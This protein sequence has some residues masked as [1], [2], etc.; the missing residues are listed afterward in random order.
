MLLE[1]FRMF[2]RCM[3]YVTEYL[4][5]KFLYCFVFLPEKSSSQYGWVGG[6][7]KGNFRIHYRILEEKE[8]G[9]NY[10]S[11]RKDRRPKDDEQMVGSKDSDEPSL[12][13]DLFCRTQLDKLSEGSHDV[14]DE[15]TCP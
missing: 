10:Q 2:T 11:N 13:I 7:G 4:P 8:T 1:K 15:L 9:K 14:E 5:Q 12:K 3:S 6:D